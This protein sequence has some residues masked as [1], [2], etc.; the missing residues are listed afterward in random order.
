MKRLTTILALAGLLV[1]AGTLPATAA[2]TDRTAETSNK[3]EQK[4]RYQNRGSGYYLDASGGGGKGTKVITWD[5]NGGAN[6]YWCMER[7]SEGGWY[8]HPSYNLNLCMDS[9]DSREDSPVIW[10]CKGNANQRFNVS[11]NLIWL[12]RSGWY[13]TDDGRGSQVFM[14]ARPSD[15]GRDAYW[16]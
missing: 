11:G 13:V 15:F 8:F 10:N 6:Q 2:T 12:R 3:C 16:D 9:P 7:A 1:A 5:W 4:N 14:S